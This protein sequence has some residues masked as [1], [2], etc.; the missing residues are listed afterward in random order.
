LTAG[1]RNGV[2]FRYNNP[3]TA[4]LQNTRLDLKAHAEPTRSQLQWLNNT[5][6]QN[7]YFTLEKQNS[8]TGDFDKI[9]TF[10]SKN[11]LTNEVYTA[12]DNEITEGANTYRIQLKMLDGSIKISDSKTILYKNLES[13]RIFPNPASDFVDIDLKKYEGKK[14]FFMCI[15]N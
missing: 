1:V 3:A 5:G 9:E 7:D 15:T 10:N 4:L 2:S 11:S 6:S 14:S 13:I 12:Y 8:L